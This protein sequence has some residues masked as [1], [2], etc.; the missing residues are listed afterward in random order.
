MP[1]LKGSN[2][3]HWGTRDDDSRL[4]KVQTGAFDPV[5]LNPGALLFPAI[6]TD[7]SLERSAGPGGQAEVAR[8]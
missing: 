6:V 7:N 1:N 5:F 8:G 3:A 2:T 4:Y